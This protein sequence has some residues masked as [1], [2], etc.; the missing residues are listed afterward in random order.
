MLAGFVVSLF[1]SFMAGLEA[2]PALI[3]GGVITFLLKL[4]LYWGEH[5]EHP[6]EGDD[7]G[8]TAIFF[9]SIITSIGAYLAYTNWLNIPD[10]FWV[11]VLSIVTATII[12]TLVAYLVSELKEGHERTKYSVIETTVSNPQSVDRNRLTLGTKVRIY[13]GSNFVE[14]NIL[15]QDQYP[16][17]TSIQINCTLD[18]SPN[19]PSHGHTLTFPLSHTEGKVTSPRIEILS[20]K[21]AT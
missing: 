4:L 1:F 7:Y 18:V 17:P 19:H 21:V 13:I 5:G 10:G 11:F 3:I 6:W 2:M 9:G 20:P 16:N 12:V 15:A 14:G 8:C